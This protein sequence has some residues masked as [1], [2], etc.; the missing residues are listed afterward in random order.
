MVKTFRKAFIDYTNANPGMSLRAWCSKAGVSYEQMKKFNQRAVEDEN[1]T[2]NV[3]DA[4]KLAN[5]AGYS[6]DEFLEDDLP[7]YRSESAS[8]YSKLTDTEREFLRVV[9]E[10]QRAEDRASKK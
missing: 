3:D 6:L 5:A 1:A 7:Q 10:R 2:T 8:L 9:A 4:R